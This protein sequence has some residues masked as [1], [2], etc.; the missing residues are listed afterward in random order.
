MSRFG[1][2]VALI[3]GAAKGMGASHARAFARE[4]ARVVLGD[5]DEEAGRALASE[6]GGT[7][8][9]TRLDVTDPGSWDSALAHAEAVF[10]PVT[11]LVNNAGVAGPFTP[12]A[13]LDPEVYRR[14]VDVDQF[15]V[16]LGMRAVLPGMVAAGRGSIVNISSTAGFSHAGTPNVAYTSAKLAVRGM[17]MAAAVEYG[18]AGVRVNSVHPGGAFSRRWSPTGWTTPAGPPSRRASRWAGSPSRRRSP[19]SCSSSPPTKPLTSPAPPTSRT[20]EC[21]PA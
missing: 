14:T 1:G 9:F 10:G 16:F 4:G 15:G 7:A 18:P 19:A 3:S 2:E 8:A 21:S 6:L 13:E 17:T 12:A 11:V 20:A 5:V